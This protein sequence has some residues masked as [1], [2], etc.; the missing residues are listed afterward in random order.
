LHFSRVT[1]DTTTVCP[2][3]AVGGIVA[4]ARA[5]KFADSF[6]V[7]RSA[8]QQLSSLRS[9]IALCASRPFAFLFPQH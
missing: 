6:P 4:R 8:I 5:E 7:R 3:G 2:R 9:A 1:R